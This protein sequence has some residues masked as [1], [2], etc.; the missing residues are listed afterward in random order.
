MDPPANQQGMPAYLRE[1]IAMLYER[2]HRILE[3]IRHAEEE[4]R[5]WE[6]DLHGDLE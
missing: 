3:D 5:E 4:L 1:K 2:L 6:C